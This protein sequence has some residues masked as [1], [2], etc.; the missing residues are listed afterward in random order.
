MQHWER[1]GSLT[2]LL[3]YRLRTMHMSDSSYLARDRVP[4]QKSTARWMVQ[5]VCKH[6]H[7]AIIGSFCWWPGYLRCGCRRA[8]LSTTFLLH[9]KSWRWKN[10]LVHTIT[11]DSSSR[12]KSALPWY[13]HTGTT[14]STRTR[15]TNLE[16][17]LTGMQA[18]TCCLPQKHHTHTCT[19]KGD[20]TD[21]A[22]TEK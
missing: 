8:A 7:P 11:A 2:L 20:V 13:R 1:W 5:S 3:C 6:T 18:K 21:A 16:H 17:N 15:A 22:A 9:V 12:Y 19:C 14:S 4:I 10:V